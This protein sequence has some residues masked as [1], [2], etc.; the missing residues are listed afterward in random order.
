MR[1]AKKSEQ[2]REQE[3][4]LKREYYQ[5]HKEERLGYQNKYY[6]KHG[7]KGKNIKANTTQK[8]RLNDLNTKGIMTRSTNRE[9]KTTGN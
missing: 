4:E 1:Y 8:I 9:R 2:E 7:E 3:R 6:G 5:E